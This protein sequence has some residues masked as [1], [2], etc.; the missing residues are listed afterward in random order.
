MSLG[1][2]GLMNRFD[3]KLCYV[4]AVKKSNSDSDSHVLPPLRSPSITRLGNLWFLRVSSIVERFDIFLLA[5][6]IVYGVLFFWQYN[7][8]AVMLVVFTV[9]NL[10]N[11]VR[12]FLLR[13]AGGIDDEVAGVVKLLE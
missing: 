5:C 8:T 7:L 12:W 1:F 6:A 3:R 9:L 2:L 4:F 11:V 13:Y 10:L